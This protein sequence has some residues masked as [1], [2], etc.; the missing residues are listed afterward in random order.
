MH[1][2]QTHRAEIWI[3]KKYEEGYEKSLS[4]GKLNMDFSE[5]FIGEDTWKKIQSQFVGMKGHYPSSKTNILF[6]Y[7]TKP[8]L[9]DLLTR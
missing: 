5:R 6:I 8:I 7:K 4:L 3:R 2:Y 1:K 9:L